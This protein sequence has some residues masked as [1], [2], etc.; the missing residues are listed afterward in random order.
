MKEIVIVPGIQC[1]FQEHPGNLHMAHA[2][3]AAVG[4]MNT[5]A[6]DPE[7]A[8][9]YLLAEQII[10]RIERALM[11]A[12]EPVELGFLE[13]HEHAGAEWLHQQRSVLCHVVEEVKHGVARVPLRAPD[14]GG[15]AVQF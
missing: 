15:Y 11:E 2:A 12:A 10:F 1:C 3:E 5:A 8:L 14:V 4:G 9:P 6:H 13:Q 7:P